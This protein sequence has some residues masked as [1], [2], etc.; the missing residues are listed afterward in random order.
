MSTHNCRV[1]VQLD[2]PTHKRRETVQLDAS[3][4]AIISVSNEMFH[5][6]RDNFQICSRKVAVVLNVRLDTQKT[7]RDNVK[8]GASTNIIHVSAQ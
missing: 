4:V 3:E 6:H 7:C 1:I 5:S 8:L 2:V